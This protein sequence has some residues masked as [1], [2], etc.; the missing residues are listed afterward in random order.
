MVLDLKMLT[1]FVAS[2][3]VHSTNAEN[4]VSLGTVDMLEG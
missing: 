4:C 3:A 1:V 2:G